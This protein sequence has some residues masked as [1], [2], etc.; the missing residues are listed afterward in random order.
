MFPAVGTRSWQC[1][2]HDVVV[3]GKTNSSYEFKYFVAFFHL[4]TLQPL[5]SAPALTQQR[6]AARLFQPDTV[7][8]PTP[9][10]AQGTHG[11]LPIPATE[12]R[13]RKS[14][15]DGV[16]DT[17]ALRLCRGTPGGERQ[18]YWST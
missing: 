10:C 15:D 14:Q 1:F 18:R 6:V 13:G 5:F 3:S 11:R 9:L 2:G 17:P 7:D 12:R 8:T 4:G 16:V